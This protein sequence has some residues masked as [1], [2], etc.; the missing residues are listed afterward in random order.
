M[1]PQTRRWDGADITPVEAGAHLECV[2]RSPVLGRCLRAL[3]AGGGPG[4]SPCQRGLL[5]EPRSG[6]A[7]ANYDLCLAHPHT[8][9]GILPSKRN[10][11]AHQELIVHSI[12]KA[13][14]NEEL[15]EAH[16]LMHNQCAQAKYMHDL[17]C[18]S[19]FWR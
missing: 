3:E 7:H 14:V 15:R 18:L 1:R 4:R 13:R 5:G 11:S 2:E 8:L 17:Q 9:Q 6:S 19:W 10:E 16:G 12:H